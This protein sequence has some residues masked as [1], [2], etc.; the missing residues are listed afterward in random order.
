MAK[1]VISERSQQPILGRPI[2]R[3]DVLLDS[4]QG[5]SRLMIK[6]HGPEGPPENFSVERGVAEKLIG[7]LKDALYSAN[8]PLPAKP[9]RPKAGRS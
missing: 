4:D 2:I 5:D 7:Q 9:T 8:L 3:F 6:V 1:P